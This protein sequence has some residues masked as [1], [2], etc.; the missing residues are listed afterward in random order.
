MAE[1]TRLDPWFHSYS[2]RSHHMKA[3][4]IRALFAVANR[5]EVV[6]LAGGMPFLDGLPL[7]HIAETSARLI[8]E[9]GTVALQYGS[10]QGI[11]ELREQITQVMAQE[12][13]TAHADDVVVTTGSQQ[14]LRS[15]EHT[16]ELQ[17]RGH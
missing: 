2:E 14:A 17:S 1:G 9:H 5:P 8:R 3:S 4:A 12:G 11:A 6:S 10:G 16:S 7:E 13:I 15:E